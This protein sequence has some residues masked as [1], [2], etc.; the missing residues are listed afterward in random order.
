MAH[1]LPK[2]YL[3]LDDSQ[4]DRNGIQKIN[5]PRE[6]GEEGKLSDKSNVSGSK[7]KRQGYEAATD[8]MNS[9]NVFISF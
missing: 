4:Y 6:N 5:V 7:E 9:K 2:K 8:K 3:F 1:V